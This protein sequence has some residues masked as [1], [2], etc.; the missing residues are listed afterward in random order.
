MCVL[1]NNIFWCAIIS[2]GLLLILQFFFNILIPDHNADAFRS[3]QDPKEY[4]SN[5]DIIVKFLFGGLIRWDAEYFIHIAK[6]GYTYENMLAFYPLYPAAIRI[7]GT[8]IRKIFFVLNVH[9]SLVIAAVLINYIFFVKSAVIFFDLSRI[10]LKRP[11]IAYKAAILYCMSPANIFF[12]AAYTESMFAYFTFYSM[13]GSIQNNVFTIVPLSLSTLV[14]SNGIINIGF[15]AYFKFKII[16]NTLYTEINSKEGYMSIRRLYNLI[17]RKKT[18]SS[19][20][21]LLSMII[22]I[23]FPFIILQI[24]NYIIFCTTQLNSSKLPIHIVDYAKTRQLVLQYNAT[25]V[26]CHVKIPIAYSY[27][28]EKYWNVGFLN[29]YELK[30]I[31][32]FIIALPTIYIMIKCIVEFYL[33]HKEQFFSLGLVNV[34]CEKEALEKKYSAEMF[35]FIIHGLFLTVFCIFF[36]HIQVTTRLLCSASPL[37]YWYSALS[38]SYESNFKNDSIHEGEQNF[39]FIW[40]IFFLSHQKY[41]LRDKFILIYFLGYTI[42]G[43]FMFVNFL[44]WT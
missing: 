28:Q 32:N 6:Y 35:V 30:Q 3:P 23:L 20:F 24:Y 44:P 12:S 42:V 10:V 11:S 43:C 2:R 29:Y 27:I 18:I 15:L 22:V 26:W 31:P 21:K 19:I 40:K 39:S 5:Y 17:I 25:S 34:K 9:S 33:E 7:I 41:T 1:K 36:V 13:L 14:R 38:L 4:V 8:I 16:C 37:I